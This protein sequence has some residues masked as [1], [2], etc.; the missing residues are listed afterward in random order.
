ME[1][2]QLQ[3][4]IESANHK[5]FSQAAKALYTTQPNISKCIHK[6]EDELHVT[7]FQRSNLGIELTEEGTL[8]YQYALQIMLIMEEMTKKLL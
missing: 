8:V 3:Y 7:L 1:I 4:F 5:S 6:L 2:R